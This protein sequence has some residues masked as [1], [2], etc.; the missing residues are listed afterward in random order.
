MPNP[1]AADLDGDGNLEIL[2]SSYDGRV[3][4]YWLDKTE[5]GN[6]PYSVHAGHAIRFASEPVVADL[7]DD[8][9]AE[10]IFGSWVQKGSDQTGKLH[11]LDYQ[12]NPVHEVDLP[13][14]FGSPDWNGAL[15]APTLANIDADADLEVVLNTAHSGFVAYEL[16]GTAG[17]RVL[18]GTGR[19]NQQRSGSS[20]HG[21]LE[22]SRISVA[23]V[24]PGPGDALT[25]TVHLENP[26]PALEGVWVTDTLA[27]EVTYRGDLW[28]S[29]GTYG[30][31]GGVVTWTGTVDAVVPVTITFGAT[32]SQQITMPQMIPNELLIDD[33]LGNVWSRQAR[34]IANG[35]PSYLPV[36]FR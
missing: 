17:A 13:P 18:W 30:E 4:A 11:I 7:D 29:S 3:H 5:H 15:A 21:S 33:G 6:W 1:V 9:H 27:A 31:A 35:Y 8:G 20:L 14:A 19:G 34:V 2:H 26:G 10:V 32:V 36:V 16:P 22:N 24:R 23:P 25:Y 12:G 28:A